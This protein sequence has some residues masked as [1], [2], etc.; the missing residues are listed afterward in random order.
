MGDSVPTIPGTKAQGDLLLAFR[1]EVA[2]ILGRKTLGFPGAQPVSFAAR[3]KLELQKQDYYVCEK[4]DG[5]RCLMYLTGDGPEEITY[6][7]D[8][9]NDYYHV[10]LLHFPI[11]SEQEREFH[12]G[13]LVDGE[14]VNDTMP[15]GSIQLKYLVFDCLILDSSS[16]MHRSLDKRLAYFRDKVF[17]PYRELYK[18]YP[19]EIQYLPFVVDFKNMEL[20]YGI[21]MMFREILPN[22]AHGNDGLIFT[23]KNSPYQFGTDPHILKWKSEGENSIDFRV[24]LEWPL[25]DPD[26]DDP[27]EDGNL[28]QYTDYSALPT[29]SLRVFRTDGKD[30]HFGYMYLDELEWEDMTVMD[31]PMDDRIVEC[32][33]DEQHRWRFLRFRDD[34]EEANHISTVLSVMESIE[35]KVS[36]DDLMTLAKFIREEWKKRQ[37]LES[38]KAKQ[39]HEARK[40]LTV[41]EATNSPNDSAGIDRKF[42]GDGISV[43]EHSVTKRNLSHDDT[44][45]PSTIQEATSSSNGPSANGGAGT[46]RKAED[47]EDSA[48]EPSTRKRKLSHSDVRTASSTQEITTSPAGATRSDSSSTKRKFE[49]DED[50]VDENSPTRRKLSPQSG[51]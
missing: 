7:I 36:K 48:S 2:Q 13:T 31:L 34:K 1:R 41:Y 49:E 8:R 19:E 15:N 25:R 10:P 20:G 9:K 26:S 43:N 33:L 6:L 50:S 21:E 35:D 46:K 24:K 29:V 16:L 30:D 14:L 28:T 40:A 3:H 51:L 47:S 44:L 22:L 12:T 32:Y 37:S 23:C 5:I 11:S 45:K 39:D 4:S 38:T 27:D 42:E 17:T 18:K